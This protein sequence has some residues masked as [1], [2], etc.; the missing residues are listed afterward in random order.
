MLSHGKCVEESVG[1][2]AKESGGRIGQVLLTFPSIHLSIFLLGVAKDTSALKSRH[3]T[4][5]VRRRVGGEVWLRCAA[6]SKYT[7]F[8]HTVFTGEVRN[9][10][11]VAD[12]F[13][14]TVTLFLWVGVSILF[15]FENLG[16]QDLFCCQ[17]LNV[18]SGTFSSCSCSISFIITIS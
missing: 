13:I 2:C 18:Y 5:E 4:V 14:I 12:F 8:G 9:K 7:F 10:V 3:A 16:S 1:K 17:T 11:V 6:L 15:Y